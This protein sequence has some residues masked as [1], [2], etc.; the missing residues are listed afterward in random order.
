MVVRFCCAVFSPENSNAPYVTE[1]AVN[2]CQRCTFS[3]KVSRG[4]NSGGWSALLHAE[5]GCS[6]HGPSAHVAWG[7]TGG[8]ETRLHLHL[9]CHLLACLPVIHTAAAKEG[10]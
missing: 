3:A 5:I 4:V 6:P 1:N 9:S 7:I 10:C 8:I 2:C